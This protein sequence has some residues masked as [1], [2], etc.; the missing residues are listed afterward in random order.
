MTLIIGLGHQM[1]VGKDT[2]AAVLQRELGFTRI[3][4]ADPLKALALATN[5]MIQSSA[6]VNVNIGHGRMRHIVHGVG[7]ER[8]KNEFP[9]VRTYLQSLGVAA[10]DTF[11]E[12][13][14]VDQ[15]LKAA[16]RHDRVVISDVRFLNEA[17][18]IRAAGGVLVKIDRPGYTAG[19]H[20]S[21][22]DLAGFDWDHTINNYSDVTGLE[23][24]ILELVRPLL[25]AEVVA[26]EDLQEGLVR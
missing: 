14:W 22:T 24:R 17:L 7:W 4:F 8:A 9:E 16:S 2:A 15:A 10:R 1:R 19:G 23:S 18:T 11:G 21:E 13:F 3:G 20:V 5:P 6:K 26:R 12:D 25:P